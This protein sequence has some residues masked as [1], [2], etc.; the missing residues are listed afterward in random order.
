MCKFNSHVR[1]HNLTENLF[2]ILIFYVVNTSGPLLI[3]P[4]THRGLLFLTSLDVGNKCL[5]QRISG[6]KRNGEKL[7]AGSNSSEQ[8]I[9]N[10]FFGWVYRPLGKHFKWGRWCY[11][12]QVRQFGWG[13][14]FFFSWINFTKHHKI[15]MHC[16]FIHEPFLSFSTNENI[17]LHWNMN[18]NLKLVSWIPHLQPFFPQPHLLIKSK[19]NMREV[20][21]FQCW[22]S[23]LPACMK[24]LLSFANPTYTG[25]EKYQSRVSKVD[26]TSVC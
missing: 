17:S 23:S 19:N 14:K 4:H 2:Y 20:L 25:R 9:L 6:G 15:T 22:H 11:H 12:S 8:G 1:I 16:T 10:I 21:L 3:F 24:L 7:A 18:G 5:I 13:N 26:L